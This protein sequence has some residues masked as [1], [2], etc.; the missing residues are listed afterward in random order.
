VLLYV[1]G[2]VLEEPRAVSRRSGSAGDDVVKD[3]QPPSA[4]VVINT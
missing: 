3:E 1:V 2:R 4:G